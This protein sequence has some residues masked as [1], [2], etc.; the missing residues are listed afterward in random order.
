M[1]LPAA[2]LAAGSLVA[3]HLPFL[4]VPHLVALAALGIAWGRRSGA[5]LAWL[6]AGAL[7]AALSCD[8]P[9]PPEGGIDSERPV[10]ATLRIA[11]PWTAER[12]GWTAPVEIE[13]MAQGE[14]VIPCRLSAFL[15]LPGDELPPPLGARLRVQG[16]LRRPAGYANREPSPPGPW[17][18]RV[19][20]RR[21]LAVE[22]GPGPLARLSAAARLPIEAAYRAAEDRTTASG[23]EGIALARA[24]VLGDAGRLPLAWRRG[25]RSAGLAHLVALSGLHVGMLAAGALLFG[26]FLPRAPR[27][28]AAALSIGAY[29][30][31]AG[32][33]PSLL[34]AAAMALLAVLALLLERPPAGAN[35]LGWAVVLLV[36][37]RPEVVLLASFRLTV[38]ATAGILLLAPPFAARLQAR[39]PAALAR[40]LAISLAAE[41]ATLPIALPLF[42]TAPPLAPLA[43]LAAIPWTALALGASFAWTTAALVSARFAAFL[44]PALDLVAAPF[45]WPATAGARLFRGVPLL[46]SPLAASLLALGLALLLLS[47]RG[48]RGRCRMVLAL[49]AL[50]AAAALIAVPQMASHGVELALLDVGQ[51]D[52]ILLRDGRRAILVD[53]GGKHGVDLGG[54]V[55]LPALLA[56][57]VQR[58]D[59]LVLTHPDAD[60][61]QGL[62]D[63]AAY[64]EVEEIW[65]APGWPPEGCAWELL[66]LPA[67][68]RVLWAGERAVVGRWHFLA[69]NPAPGDRRGVNVRSLVL[70]AEANGRRALL[71]GDAEAP[72]ERRML[73]ELGDGGLRADILKVGHHGSKTSTTDDFLAAISPRLALISDGIANVYHHPSPVVLRRLQ[74]RAIPTL[75]TDRD[76]EVVVRIGEGGALRIELPGAPR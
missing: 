44:V 4:P 43:N 48:R 31:V 61:C 50:L 76:G 56:E 71:T 51:G 41:L 12:E 25:L 8:L 66:S 74:K 30:L 46:A 1:L 34:R 23:G 69:L 2:A 67:R 24:L 18:L 35:A 62:V 70:L 21:L 32:P 5:A 63:L 7:T 16:Y 3:F 60:H 39:L 22:A 20:S 55:L 42:H 6:A 28:L 19:K 75:R 11:G 33:L 65:T 72:A 52:A 10:A 73:R 64:V 57:G 54:R 40:P 53:G 37:H 9:A 47:G 14:G 68:L 15:D 38:A 49:A 58:L 13:R 27:L 26:A 36:L 17:R 29:L 45:G 59:A